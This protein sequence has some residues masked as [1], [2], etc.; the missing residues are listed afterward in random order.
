MV[1]LCNK[2]YSISRCIKSC[3]FW[4]DKSACNVQCVFPKSTKN[5]NCYFVFNNTMLY[6]LI[7][8][9]HHPKEEQESEPLLF[10]GLPHPEDASVPHISHQYP[11][12]PEE[13]EGQW[14][15]RTH[16]EI[17]TRQE[18][19]PS[20][21]DDEEEHSHGTWPDLFGNLGKCFRSVTKSYSLLNSSCL[22]DL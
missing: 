11:T 14:P 3:M 13:T 6:Y 2:Q 21:L 8:F 18:V 4:Y 19:L 22:H 10:T 5:C 15:G 17:K 1:C 20:D 16:T 9:S 7:F 12:Q